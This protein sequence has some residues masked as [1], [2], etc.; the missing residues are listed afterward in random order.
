MVDYL[1]DLILN[2]FADEHQA[3]CISDHSRSI[4][5]RGI[6]TCKVV[7][8]AEGIG[9]VVVVTESGAEGNMPW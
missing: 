4:P 2:A 7:E 8:Q 5:C 1:S 6:G 9:C 3:S